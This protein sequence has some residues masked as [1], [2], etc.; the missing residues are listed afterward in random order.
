MRITVT[1]SRQRARDVLAEELVR[2]LEDAR[3]MIQAMDRDHADT[4]AALADALRQRGHAGR[5]IQTA[6]AKLD[7]AERI[8]GELVRVICED[9]ERIASQRDAIDRLLAVLHSNEA[10]YTCPAIGCYFIA[11]GDAD[12]IYGLKL[13]HIKQ[14]GHPAG[15]IQ[16]RPYRPAP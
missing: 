12:V 9:A 15:A 8:L 16:H 1:T 10:T 13:K 3:A 5:I 2:Q 14:T 4:K 6:G 7:E 11:G